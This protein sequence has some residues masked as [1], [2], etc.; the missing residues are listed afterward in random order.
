MIDVGNE[1]IHIHVYNG[2]QNEKF[3]FRKS[4]LVDTPLKVRVK[5]QLNKPLCEISI[6][7]FTT[8]WSENRRGSNLPRE[9]KNTT[10]QTST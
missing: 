4:S 2:E 6:S 8:N 5:I 1:N 3:R 10:N 7:K 9:K